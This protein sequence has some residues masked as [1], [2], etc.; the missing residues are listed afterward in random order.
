[1]QFTSAAYTQEI[2]VAVMQQA[3]DADVTWSG[4]VTLTSM[5]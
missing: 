4:T 1:V 5:P 3:S 2:P